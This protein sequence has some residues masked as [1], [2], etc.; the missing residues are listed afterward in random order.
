MHY[1]TTCQG[2]FHYTAELSP[3][4][5]GENSRLSR[6]GPKAPRPRFVP[7]GAFIVAGEVFLMT[8]KYGVGTMHF[9]TAYK[10]VLA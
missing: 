5:A 4:L 7:E 8:R 2:Q 10:G 9:V 1:A 3:P 6:L